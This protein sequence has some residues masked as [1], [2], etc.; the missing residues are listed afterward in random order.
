MNG[1]SSVSEHGGSHGTLPNPSL[2]PRQTPNH[3]GFHS[4]N[5]WV[6]TRTP[7]G[8]ASSGVA[9]NPPDISGHN[10]HVL[11]HKGMPTHV[12]NSYSAST[13]NSYS[14]ATAPT[15]LASYHQS[16]SSDSTGGYPASTHNHPAYV[17]PNTYPPVGP[18]SQDMPR[19]TATDFLFP[20]PASV[21]SLSGPPYQPASAIYLNSPGNVVAASGPSSWQYWANNFA[22]NLEPEEYMSSAN[23][24]MQL[25]GH[26][27]QNV[28]GNASA[29]ASASLPT[30][31]NTILENPAASEIASGQ[32]RW[33]LVVF[34]NEQDA[35]GNLTPHAS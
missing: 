31:E 6:D 28:H 26:G 32:P 35:A 5:Q 12:E 21:P 34:G 22:S 8:G 29:S 13:P 20:S 4:T 19:T 33:P 3:E 14:E 15:R 2:P 10:H 17:A 9:A 7:G 25:G 18:D 1:S 27:D 16:P 24:L 30:M 23:A 11:G